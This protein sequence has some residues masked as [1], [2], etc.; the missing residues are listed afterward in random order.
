MIK[1]SKINNLEVVKKFTH[2]LEEAFTNRQFS[3][4]VEIIPPLK[5]GTIQEIYNAIEPLIKIGCKLISVTYHREEVKYIHTGNGLYKKIVV[6]RR[7]GTVSIAA[8]IQYKY[9][10]PTMPHLICGGFTKDETESALIDL[11]YLNINNVLAIRGDPMPGQKEFVSEP[12]GHQFA[13]QLVEQISN[14]NKGIYLYEET[15]NKTPTDFCIGVA[16]YPEKH[17]IAPSL[18][19]DIRFL[20]NKIQKGAHFVITQIFFDNNYFFDFVNLCKSNNIT[21]PIVPGIKPLTTKKQLFTIPNAFHIRIPEKLT[22]KVLNEDNPDKI[23]EMGIN[24]ALHQCL[25]LID[26]GFYHIH[27]YSMGKPNPIVAIV[28]K[29]QEK[30]P[31]LILK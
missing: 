11:H 29:I 25:E 10:I 8:A 14:M 26:R 30:K 27:F 9:G 7:P 22:D 18:S 3:F 6:K 17:P 24:W 20:Y 15:Q 31:S 1:L 28:Q 12:D 19:T 4:S 21:V 2:I 13:Y 5:G 23:E 16:G